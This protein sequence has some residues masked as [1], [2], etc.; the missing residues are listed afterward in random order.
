MNNKC[1]LSMREKRPQPDTGS[2]TVS[3]AGQGSW[4]NRNRALRLS[5]NPRLA[6]SRFQQTNVPRL[7]CP[8]QQPDF[9]F[10]AGRRPLLPWCRG[11]RGVQ[12]IL[13]AI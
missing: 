6:D 11:E 2:V 5:E 9:N 1:G 8:R 10:L 4:L 13:P 12:S 3:I 7:C